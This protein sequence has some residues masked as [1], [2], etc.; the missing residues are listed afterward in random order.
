MKT[1]AAAI[2]FLATLALPVQAQSKS[3]QDTINKAKW[4]KTQFI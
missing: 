4:Y 3:V 2:M 1:I